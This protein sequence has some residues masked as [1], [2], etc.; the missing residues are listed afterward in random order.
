MLLAAE[1]PSGL[2]AVSVAFLVGGYLVVFALWYF[3]VFRPSRNERASGE[4]IG[5][6]S[7]AEPPSDAS[8][9]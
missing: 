4:P 2:V 8:G 6:E 9:P 3:M 5:A 7:E 1:S